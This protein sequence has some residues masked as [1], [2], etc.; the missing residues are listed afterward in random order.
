MVP[1]QRD[2]FSSVFDS[3][4]GA[5]YVFGGRAGGKEG[6]IHDSLVTANFGEIMGI[7]ETQPNDEE[8]EGEEE[9]GEEEGGAA[10]GRKQGKGN[11][12]GALP[13]IDRFKDNKQYLSSKKMQ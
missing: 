11:G 2:F 6:M 5:L 10:S 3:T 8:E 4:E 13:G 12:K 9:E 7:V 1:G